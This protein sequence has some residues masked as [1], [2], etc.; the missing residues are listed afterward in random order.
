MQELIAERPA[1][2]RMVCCAHLQSYGL[3]TATAVEVRCKCEVNSWHSSL[4]LSRVHAT[5][6]CRSHRR[7]CSRGIVELVGDEL[8]YAIDGIELGSG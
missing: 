1:P 5:G 8:V 7:S 2:I 6:R 3:R 4:Y